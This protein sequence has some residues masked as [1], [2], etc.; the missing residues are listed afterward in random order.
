MFYT[1]KCLKKDQLLNYRM[2]DK[3]T[4]PLV[5]ICTP[6]FNRRPFIKAAIECF[7]HQDYPLERMEW[8]IIDDGTDK[9]RISTRKQIYLK[10]NTT[11]MIKR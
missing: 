4:R 1:L 3:K 10:S 2:A 9:I 7:K 11:L 6:T 8:V 5:S